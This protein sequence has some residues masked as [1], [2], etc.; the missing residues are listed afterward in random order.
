MFKTLLNLFITFTKIGLVGYGGGPAMVP[1]IQEEAVERQEWMS[2]EEFIDT[3]AMGNTL[4][5]PLATKMALFVGFQV[6]GWPGAVVGLLG[7]LWPSSALMMVMGIFFL[8]FK[9]SP[10]GQAMI[11][12]IRPVVISLLS[13]TVYKFIPSSIRNWHTGLI[14]VASF[15]AVAFLKIHPV[16]V[17][18]VVAILG[19]IVYR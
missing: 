8:H 3:V 17:I 10:Y 2:D 19:M 1:L 7:M 16:L 12:A 4:P 9:D 15:A 5:G 13:Y 18:L 6:C 14:A 11:T